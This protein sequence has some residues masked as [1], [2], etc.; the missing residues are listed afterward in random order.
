MTTKYFTEFSTLP[1]PELGLGAETYKVS[2]LFSGSHSPV[3]LK[4]GDTPL[5]IA[6]ADG[7]D[8]LF[9]P[10]REKKATIQLIATDAVDLDAFYAQ[11]D[12]ECQVIVEKGSEVIF[13]GWLTAFDA[14][15]PFLC[16]PY[17]FEL[18]A[19]CGLSSLKDFNFS[20]TGLISFNNA[21]RQCLAS[22][23]LNLNYQVG[24]DTRISGDGGDPTTLYG[25]ESEALNGK[26]CYDTLNLILDSFVGD[27]EQSG[28]KWVL[29]GLSE[30]AEG[31][32]T[33]Y[34]Y[35]AGGGSVGTSTSGA[36]ASVGRSVTR[37]AVTGA[38]VQKEPAVSY[39]EIKYDLGALRNL[40]PNGSFTEQT[41][42][43]AYNYDH[44]D[45][46]NGIVGSK[47]SPS[48]VKIS[49]RCKLWYLND[50]GTK[51]LDENGKVPWDLKAKFLGYYPAFLDKKTSSSRVSFSRNTW[52]LGGL[53][54]TST[55]QHGLRKCCG[56]I[57]MGNGRSSGIL[58]CLTIPSKWFGCT[59][60]TPRPWYGIHSR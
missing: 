60:T 44:W 16:R 4:A 5:R 42:L 55:I 36:V 25:F 7:G 11:S 10:I 51:V 43:G 53:R 50:D 33:V 20:A 22:T 30:Q 47:Q 28:G 35:L 38:E 34:E 2:F 54:C 45:R 31:S 9:R 14:K 19:H 59:E 18:V 39:V 48:G 57:K 52:I 3:E 6:Y 41:F 46:Y 21:I 49:G 40:L 24:V 8:D 13:K 37:R 56:L 17:T 58:C 12:R 27:V 29:R 23:G 32:V 26:S 1:L 15:E